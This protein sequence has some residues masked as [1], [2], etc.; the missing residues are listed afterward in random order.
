MQKLLII[1]PESDFLE[2]AQRHLTTDRVQVDIAPNAEE[3]MKKFLAQKPDLVIAEFHLKPVNGIE[4]LKR[5]RQQDPQIMVVLCTSFPPTNAVIE[6]MK[7]GAFD[8]LRKESLPYDLRPV[9]E[10]ALQTREAS[11]VEKP[12]LEPP[13]DLGD[14]MIGQSPA[15]QGVFKM[16]GRVSRSDAAV[17]ITGESGCGKEVVARAIQR[18]S[19]RS[20]RE[21]VAI[22]CAAIP[23]SLLESELFGHEKGSFTGATTQRVG[24]FE[25]C[26]G[27]TLFLDEIGE[28]PMHVQTKILRVL[29][30]GEF[31]RVGGNE[32]L[33]TDVRIIAATNRNLER[34]VDR[35]KFREDLFYRLNVVRVHLPP[36]RERP[37]DIRPLALFFLQR[38]A[39]KKNNPRL[40]F[41]DDALTFMES[42]NWPG[43]VRELENT[44]Q[45][46]VVL[47]RSEVLTAEDLPLGQ[48]SAARPADDAGSVSTEAALQQLINAAIDS[49]EPAL[50][51]IERLLAQEML[52]KYDN[53][54][55]AA[56]RA[57][58]LK[59][60]AFKKLLGP[61]VSA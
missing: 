36:L 34:E 29:Q 19:Q 43:N 4:L 16:I 55:A 54:S 5:L 2:W 22:N 42:Y 6:A 49:G 39:R 25:Q 38:L 57:L 32:T 52:N 40:R 60:A 7:L 35:G 24:R 18:F 33:R 61:A 21:F 10:S 58:G 1:D 12:V 46:A 50:A 53:D 59:P 28:M 23:E 17:M 27:G 26:D 30:E 41:A 37:E 45:R 56:A 44:I 9:V 11:K 14:V 47:A 13:V 8:F 20:G 48:N 51:W 3:G 15:M 31:S